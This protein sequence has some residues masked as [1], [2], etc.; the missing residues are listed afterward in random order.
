MLK[1]YT[2]AKSNRDDA[3][4]SS[5]FRT[6]K[7]SFLKGLRRSY[8]LPKELGPKARPKPTSMVLKAKV[9]SQVI[10]YHSTLPTLNH[11]RYRGSQIGRIDRIFMHKQPK[12]LDMSSFMLPLYSH[13]EILPRTSRY[14]G[15]WVVEF[16][17]QVTRC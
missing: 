4:S 14:S 15:M 12:A 11:I 8:E 1:N 5:A 16:G 3:Q 17:R 6:A 7:S 9:F 13:R 10:L 2:R